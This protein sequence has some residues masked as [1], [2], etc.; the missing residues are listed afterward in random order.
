[1]M[2]AIA[3][4]ALA[5]PFVGRAHA[6]PAGADLGGVLQNLFRSSSGGAEGPSAPP[7]VPVRRGPGQPGD[8]ASPAGAELVLLGVVIAGDTRMALIQ[9]ETAH[10]SRLLRIGETMGSHRLAG[11]QPDRAI[12]QGSGGEQ[13]VLRL[14]AGLSVAGA[15]SPVGPSQP[16]LEPGAGPASEATET[17]GTSLSRRRARRAEAGAEASADGTD[18]AK[19]RQKGGGKKDGAAKPNR[20]A[21]PGRAGEPPQAASPAR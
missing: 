21:Q 9:D 19:P 12:L 5:A 1:M 8:A 4:G 13:L 16:Q 10:G 7:P 18:V 20:R 17:A 15:G 2:L 3:A 6:Q 14:G 11:V